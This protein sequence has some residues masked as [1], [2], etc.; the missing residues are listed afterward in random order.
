M[1]RLL[2]FVLGLVASVYF[3][4]SP[5]G[6]LPH[7]LAPIVIVGCA[8]RAW[9]RVSASVLVV[10]FLSAYFT[11]FLSESWIEFLLLPLIAAAGPILIIVKLPFLGL[12]L[13]TRPNSG[14]ARSLATSS[15]S[16]G[17]FDTAQAC[18]YLVKDLGTTSR[19]RKSTHPRDSD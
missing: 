5:S 13:A 16:S 15:N 10:S 1:E 6:T 17:N 19:S 2:L 4:S 14:S 18:R 8:W 3:V 9:G 12:L 11:N 7:S